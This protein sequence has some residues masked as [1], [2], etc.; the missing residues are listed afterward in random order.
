MLQTF[1]VNNMRWRKLFFAC[2]G[3][4]IGSAFCMKWMESDFWAN[5]S[6]F[7]I[8]G[9]EI[10]YSR[11]ELVDVVKGMT[12]PVRLILRYH[13]SFDFAFMAGVYPA[14]VAALMLGREKM[15]TRKM[16]RFFLLLACLQFIAWACDVAENAYLF[17]W[18]ERAPS[19]VEFGTYHLVVWMKWLL[20]LLG[21]AFAIGAA[22]RRNKRA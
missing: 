10:F 2:M 16:K 22:I 1:E 8:L 15:Q 3:L 4:A 19:E 18:L 13:L 20:V 17:A 21:I 11:Q 12:A 7:T 5:G 9:L 14:V 6:R